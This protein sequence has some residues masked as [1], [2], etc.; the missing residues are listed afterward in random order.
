MS[1]VPPSVQLYT[2]RSAIAD[3]LPGTLARLA[4]LGFTKVEPW[5][6]V[7]RVDEY[8]ELLPASG[9]SAPSAHAGL[10][11]AAAKDELDPIFAAAKRLGVS[12]IIDPHIDET[13][14]I[15]RE[16]V[17]SIARDLGSV[18]DRAA[19]HDLSVG[20]HNHAFELENLIDGVPA[21]EILAGALPAGVVLEVDTYWAEV[22]GVDA[23]ELLARLGD[24]VQFLHVKDGPKTK[25]DK[26]QVA[27]GRGVL[28]IRDILRAAPQAL[29]VIELDDHEG[30]IFTA[31]EESLAFL[32]KIRA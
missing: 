5:G 19:E 20:Y 29:P 7:E 4:A 24:R 27:V 18:A 12:T 11:A 16:D 13:R 25:N 14:W 32:E 31:L 2:V 22:G 6:F 26:E 28:P 15:T 8:A 23:P 21:L 3:D 9:L 17:E 10:V 30:D 1:T